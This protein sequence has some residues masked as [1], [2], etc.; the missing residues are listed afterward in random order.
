MDNTDAEGRVTLADSIYYASTVMKATKVIDLVTLTGA[1]LVAFGE[2][3]TGA[4]TN[5][6][7][8]FNQVVSAAKLSGENI[9]QLP[10][11]KKFAKLNKSRVADI[12]NTG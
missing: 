3:Y 7:E 8:F 2:V 9:W 10:T 11:D 5:N 4:V 1:C 12:K 6:Q